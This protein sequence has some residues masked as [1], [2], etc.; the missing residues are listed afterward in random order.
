MSNFVILHNVP[1]VSDTSCR[2]DGFVKSSQGA[3][4]CTNFVSALCERSHEERTNFVRAASRSKIVR[5]G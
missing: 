4:D 5:V 3:G 2:L 1:A